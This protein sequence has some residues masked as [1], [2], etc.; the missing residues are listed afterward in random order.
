MVVD[1]N[2]GARYRHIDPRMLLSVF[3]GT[4]E[5]GTPNFGNSHIGANRCWVRVLAPPWIM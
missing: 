1:K 2:R 3:K 4:P 5:N